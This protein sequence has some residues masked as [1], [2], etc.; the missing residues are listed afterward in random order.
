[1]MTGD[2]PPSSRETGVRC[3]A[4]AAETTLATAL[5]PVYKT[6]ASMISV[7]LVKLELGKGT[8]CDPIEARAT[9]Y[10]PE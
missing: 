3:L 7:S 1:M 8:N 5:P 10:S 9:W 6:E 4:A 2:F